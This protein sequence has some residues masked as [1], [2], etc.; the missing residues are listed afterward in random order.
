MGFHQSQNS[1]TYRFD[2]HEKGQPSRQL[3]IRADMNVFRILGI[4][5]QDG[6]SLSG[7]KL[8]T[9][10]ERGYD[11]EHELTGDDVRSYVAAKSLAEAKR[12]EKRQHPRRRS[13]PLEAQQKSPWRNSGP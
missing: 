8:I 3:T 1:R 2:V 7:N 5:I 12:A 10:L 11:G 4:G 9:D 13:P 6:P